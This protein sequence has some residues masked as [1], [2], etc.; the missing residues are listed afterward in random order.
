MIMSFILGRFGAGAI[1]FPSIQPPKITLFEIFF[2]P[3]KYGNS[4]VRLG[5]FTVPRFVTV[6]GGH[7]FRLSRLP[8]SRDSLQRVFTGT[9]GA[10]DTAPPAA[11]SINPGLRR[12]RKPSASRVCG[13]LVRCTGLAHCL[14]RA[15][16]SN[17]ALA[18]VH[19]DRL[20]IHVRGE[21]RQK[22]HGELSYLFRLGQT[23]QRYVCGQDVCPY[24]LG[25]S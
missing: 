21:I 6:W 2:A 1:Q 5:P 15:A 7:P 25:L 20:A 13:K 11:T 24:R 4:S 17:G 12:N 22:E 8:C 18:L 14:G 19:V 3:F 23:S 9:A 10:P 16:G